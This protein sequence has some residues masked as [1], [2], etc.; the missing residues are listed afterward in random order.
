MVCDRLC[1]CRLE[2]TGEYR[3]NDLIPLL[4]LPRHFPQ[5]HSIHQ[6]PY[7]SLCPFFLDSP[8]FLQKSQRSQLLPDRQGHTQR[9]MLRYVS[10]KS[11][12]SQQAYVFVLVILVEHKF[13]Y[14]CSSVGFLWRISVFYLTA[15]SGLREL[16]LMTSQVAQDQ[17]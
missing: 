12:S 2:A 1:V 16:G 8:F 9:N 4:F 13:I 7:P 14:R 10:E 6:T 17:S 15:H 3:A 5:H 11:A